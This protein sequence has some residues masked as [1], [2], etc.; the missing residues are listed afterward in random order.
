MNLGNYD[1]PAYYWVRDG[2][3]VKIEKDKRFPKVT[4]D[5]VVKVYKQNENVNDAGLLQS[6]QTLESDGKITTQTGY[7]IQ[8]ADTGVFGGAVNTSR[9]DTPWYFGYNIDLKGNGSYDTRVI[10]TNNNVKKYFRLVSLEN[11][12]YKYNGEDVP[13]DNMYVIG[14]TLGVFVDDM[15][16]LYTGN[17][18]GDNNEVL[19]TAVG[20]NNKYYSYWGA[21]IEDPKTTIGKMTI[22]EYNMD[23]QEIINDVKGIYGDNIKDIQITPLKSTNGGS[24]SLKR[25]GQYDESSDSYKGDYFVPGTVEIT[26]MGGFEGKDIKIK[27]ANKNNKG[28]E[29]SFTINAGSKVIANEGK[30]GDELESLS[31]NGKTFNIVTQPITGEISSN[32]ILTL[33]Q[34]K[35]TAVLG[36]IKDWSIVKGELK[37]NNLVLTTKNNYNNNETKSIEIKGLASLDYVDKKDGLNVKYDND[38]KDKITL[39]PKQKAVVITNVENGLIAKD[40]KEAVNGGQLYEIKQ[41]AMNKL[42]DTI[43]DAIKE[44]GSIA[45][46]D[47][48]LVENENNKK[49][50][51]YTVSANNDIDL[52]V[53][54]KLGNKKIITIDNIAK[55]NDIGDIEKL[56]QDLKSE[57]K[58]SIVNAVN[59]LNN[60]VGKLNYSQI[61][62][63]NIADNDNTTIAIGKL[64]NKLDQVNTSLQ[65]MTNEI[66]NN[67]IVGGKINQDGSISVTQNNKTKQIIKL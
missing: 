1:N 24:I 33:Q 32:G 4:T 50:G 26:S 54:D 31:I 21:E 42:D 61:K 8:N 63:D 5:V 27:V 55:A 15:G 53:K 11:G 19:M 28:E 51:H 10:N 13:I 37:D 29:N 25:N 64:N 62:G 44:N 43:Q 17:V 30:E 60:K 67:S 66:A 3:T 36:K 34:G 47:K 20:E 23:R 49:N 7:N 46:S 14:N 39:N 59:N 35:N 48:H 6:Y 22:S 18:Y 58:T 41:E 65:N 52:I 12:R 2:Y 16:K 38:K 40:S 57:E 56:D 45:N 9:T